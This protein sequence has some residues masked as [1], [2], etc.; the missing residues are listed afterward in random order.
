MKLIKL[1]IIR[2]DQ[3]IFG[4]R[5]FD[6]YTK[7]IREKRL[8]KYL[9]E[10]YPFGLEVDYDKN[11]NS[12]LNILCDKYGSDKGGVTSD[13]NP[14]IWPS[15]TYADV[16]ELLFQLRRND[17][18]LVIECG[19]GTNNLNLQS[20]MGVD[21]RPGASLRVWRD[22][23]PRAEIIGIDID[24]DILFKDERIRTYRCDQTSKSSIEQFINVSRLQENSVDIIID[25]GLHEFRAGVS[26]FESLGKCLADNGIYI[27][28]DITQPDYLLYKDYFGKK[29]V[30]FSARFVH[31]HRPNLRVGDNRLIIITRAVSSLLRR[32]NV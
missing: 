19:L 26:L 11:S 16:Y 2:V 14:Y 12:L 13:G 32:H 23:F 28:E 24:S 1:A 30:D 20:S 15:H 29:K 31:L 9:S 7:H 3:I 8:R 21:G 10:L 6:F 25:D 4:G 27:I 5:A 22:Y 17:V 18:K